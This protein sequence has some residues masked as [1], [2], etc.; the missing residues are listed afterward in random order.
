M[1]LVYVIILVLVLGLYFKKAFSSHPDLLCT[2]I[3]SK[4]K[5]LSWNWYY[6]LDGF[7]MWIMGAFWHIYIINNLAVNPKSNYLKVSLVFFYILLF[8]SK[9]LKSNAASEIW[10]FVVNFGAIFLLLVQK[11]APENYFN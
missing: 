7:P 6:D 4:E 11:F 10:C 8:L 9:Y 5:T 1:N 3:C 2:G